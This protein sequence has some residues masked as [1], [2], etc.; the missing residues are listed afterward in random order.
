M[1]P[2]K[3]F[4]ILN[5]AAVIIPML[6]T[7]AAAL[8]FTF[9]SSGFSGVPFSSENVIKLAEQRFD[10]FSSKNGLLERKPEIL[11]DSAFQVDLK[12][13]LSVN[14]TDFVVR[15]NYK[16]IFAS[17]EISS[18]EL[19]KCLLEVKSRKPV[20]TVEFKG[21]P[22]LIKEYTFS[23]KDGDA[24]NLIL[25][26]PVTKEDVILNKL[27]LLIGMVFFAS[28]IV[29]N[30]LLSR[31]FTK[32]LLSPLTRLKAAAGEI[33]AG[34]LDYEVIEEGDGVI[35]E[36]SRS[37]E[38]M[39]LKLKESVY[40]QMKLDDSRKVLVSSISH[41]LR[42][43]ITS[44][45]GY[46][47]GVLDG[48]ANNPEKVEKY[49]K[50]AYIKADQLDTMI[51][52]LFLYSRL[53]TKQIPFNFQMTDMVAYFEDCTTEYEAE[54]EK[55]QI[56]IHMCNEILECRYAVIDRERM[57]RVVSNILDNSRRFMN[58]P[59]GKIDIVLRETRQDIIV[60]IR[61][62]GTGIPEHDLRRI[63]DRFYRT[64][65]ARS[66]SGS[67]LGLAI[68]RQILEEHGGKIW[69]RSRLNEGTGIIFSLKKAT[70]TGGKDLYHEKNIN[71]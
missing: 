58:K 5:I 22:F 42:T 28:F 66:S 2:V 68:A 21:L 25:F 38:Q 4:M 33:S 15:K 8:A 39:R 62:N 3:R 69:A 35:R 19:E 53:D 7:F 34:N 23:F 14:K 1:N 60:E 40:N 65:G 49:L 59:A 56:E 57:K 67:G 36:L 32:R 17:L 50:T 9:F 20:N 43:P 29:V 70:E 27:L 31:Y 52:D 46:I 37:F 64:D 11:L 12:N 26:T 51:D 10:L 55:A 48:V 63:F 30:L 61:D 47:S 6:I 54:L 13:L 18:I 71:C 44:I 24:G 45:K 41:D 16:I